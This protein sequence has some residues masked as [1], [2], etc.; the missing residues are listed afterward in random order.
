MLLASLTTEE[1][2]MRCR[3]ATCGFLPPYIL[4]HL[5]DRG[6]DEQRALAHATLEMSAYI[7]GERSALAVM[8][9]MLAVA[10]G[11]KRRTVYD[12]ANTR[13]LPGKRVRGEGE[14]RSGKPAVDEAYDGSGKTYDFF[15]DVLGR[16]SIDGRGMRLDS[17]VHFGVR[18]ANAEWNGRQMIYGDG[19]GY[20]FNRF[21]RSL[22]VIAHELTHGVTQYTANLEYADQSG[23]L[24]EHFSDVFGVLVKQYST[25]Q[26]A[27][28]ADWLIGA[29]LLSKRVHG[30]AVRSMKA[31]GTAYDD[32]LLGKDPQPA[33]MKQY[34]RTD[35]DNGGVHTNSGIP[36]HAFYRAAVTIGGNAWE[37]AGKIWFRALTRH[38]RGDAT[39]Q[40]CADA[41]AVAAGELFGIGSQPAD[42]VVAAWR[43]VGVPVSQSAA[44]ERRPMI[45]VARFD[46]PSAAAEVPAE[47]PGVKRSSRSTRA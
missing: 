3:R 16:N 21:T 14:R 2:P 20:L 5:A 29:D 32:P 38:L 8:P 25:K 13:L 17:T 11:E 45:R 9:A 7:R 35:E 46:V 15:L 47:R 10:A 28:D 19:D 34:L 27:R 33:H 18:F 30:V 1:V 26:A 12:A 24:N 39:F 31:P 44:E 37:V 23:A 40:E 6:D 4:R 42:A 36:N 43:A 41:T 22:D